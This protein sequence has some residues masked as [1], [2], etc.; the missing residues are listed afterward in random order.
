VSILVNWPVAAAIACVLFVLLGL[1]WLLRGDRAV[2]RM[3][4]TVGVAV[5]TCGVATGHIIVIAG[6]VIILA[7]VCWCFRSLR[8]SGQ[9][10]RGGRA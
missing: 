2:V 3:C 9:R 5:I 10:R 1:T 6:G 7:V 4:G 8:E